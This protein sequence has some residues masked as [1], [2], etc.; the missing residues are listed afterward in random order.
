MAPTPILLFLHGVGTGDPGDTWQGA[1]EPTLAR[2][3][4][5]DLSKIRVIAPKYPNGLRGVDDKEPVPKLTVKSLRGEDAKKHRRAFERRQAAMEARLGRDE[6]GEGWPAVGHAAPFVIKHIEQATNYITKPEIRAWVLDRIIKRLPASGHL[7]IVGHSLGSVIAADL[8]RRLPTGL[9]VDG[10]VTIGSPLGHGT[11]LVEPLRKVLS[12]PPA[13]LAWWVNFRSTADPVPTGRG[14][15]TVFPWVLDQRIPAPNPTTAHDASTYLGNEAVAKTIGLGLFGSQSKELVLVGKGLDVPLEPAETLLLLALRYAH[16]EAGQLEAGDKGERYADALRCVQADAVE[17]VMD[18]RASVG[19]P[20][21][22]AI[23]KLAVDISDPTSGTPAPWL[24]GDLSEA[25]AVVPLLAVANANVIQPFEI[26]VSREKRRKAMELLAFD[27]ELGTRYGADVVESLEEARK[28][29]KP[30]NWMKW[31]VLGLGGVAIFAA[32]GGLALAAAPGVAGAAA[33]TSALAAFGPGG[34]I[35]GLLTA[36]TLVSAGGGGIAIGLAAPGTTVETAE[37]WVA[38]QLAATL[39]RARR[40]LPRDDQA[41]NTLL[42]ARIEV[43]RQMRRLA[44]IS[45]ESAPTVKALERKLEAIERALDHL[46]DLGLRP[47]EAEV[48]TLTEE[49]SE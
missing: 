4:Y 31:A 49:T 21:P 1:L 24:P 38:S 32:T 26:E 11:L 45:D 36:G 13:N 41:W 43:T 19:M 39:L 9:K 10:L 16:L 42:D 40:G 7:V 12:E 17:K 23:A 48:P 34:M 3:G 22:S 27:M 5:P 35:G 47:T 6:R 2:V 37:A 29:L 30:T 25:D 28:V 33:L 44:A 46:H 15:S 20:V 8:L 14:V 18:W